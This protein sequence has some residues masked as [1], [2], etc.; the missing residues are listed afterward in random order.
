MERAGQKNLVYVAPI[1]ILLATLIGCG[2]GGGNS[3]SFTA[4]NG[5]ISACAG[6]TGTA[7]LTWTAPILNVDGSQAV[8]SEFRIYCG[9]PD[10]NLQLARTVDAAET[11]AV[12][13]TLSTGT[14]Y[15]TVTAVSVT[16]AEGDYSNFATKS[17]PPSE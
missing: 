12:F 14:T 5:L 8:L 6:G 4:G 1:F 11:T 15:F 17:I 16:G 3:K 9:T 13:D 7:A 2:G 10:Q